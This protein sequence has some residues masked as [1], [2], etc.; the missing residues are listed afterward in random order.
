[1]ELYRL[2]MTKETFVFKN[3]EDREIFLKKL[4]RTDSFYARGQC[5]IE[6]FPKLEELTKANKL[7]W[8]RGNPGLHDIYMCDFSTKEVPLFLL[9]HYRPEPSGGDIVYPEHCFQVIDG[10]TI[11]SYPGDIWCREIRSLYKTV[12]DSFMRMTQD[13]W[14][15]LPERIAEQ[16]TAKKILSNLEQPYFAKIPA[17]SE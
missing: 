13:M 2:K 15:R 7:I 14:E 5:F 4:P 3:V 11:H 12:D 8:I 16:D 10:T 1:M 6:L 9:L 17:T